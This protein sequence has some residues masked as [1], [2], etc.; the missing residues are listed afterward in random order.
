MKPTIKYN[1]DFDFI[2]FIYLSANV[3]DIRKIFNQEVKLNPELNNKAVKKR[4]LELYKEA[5]TF[6]NDTLTYIQRNELDMF[7]KNVSIFEHYLTT[8]SF[9]D[10]ILDDQSL[11]DFKSFIQKM[12]EIEE[13]ALTLETLT[14]AI[15]KHYDRPNAIENYDKEAELILE[16][17]KDERMFNSIFKNA[18]RSLKDTFKAEK[19]IP[20]KE[21]LD[22][23]LKDH[24]KKMEADPIKFILDLTSNII[25][26][27]E[28]KN[29][30]L[31]PYMTFCTQY[32]LMLSAKE[33]KAIVVYHHNLE[34]MVPENSEQ[35]LIQSLLKFLSDPKRYQM[36]QMLSKEKSCATELAKK[37]K[38][39]PATMSYHVNKL[40]A[41]GL[42]SFEQGEQNKM[43]MQLDKERLKHM[44]SQV[45]ND[46]VDDKS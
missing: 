11:D 17:L 7:F 18:I 12:F 32:K 33:D 28:L 3:K 31:T 29:K 34:K 2:S 16:T 19:Y 6:Y 37:F 42:I 25:K 13:K 8:L 39:T 5:N 24:N 30:Q 1:I 43:Y 35:D 38:I 20:M 45:T 9:K 27:D 40:F 36:V 10:L 26:E 14:D 4:T 41:L 23:K 46:L 21:I 44:L 15:K 22:E